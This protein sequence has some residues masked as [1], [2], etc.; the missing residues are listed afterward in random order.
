[1]LSTL[2]QHGSQPFKVHQPQCVEDVLQ[3]LP[4][5]REGW[6]Q[7]WN[8]IT[9]ELPCEDFVCRCVRAALEREQNAALF[10]FTSKNDKELGYILAEDNSQGSVREA[11]LIYAAYSNGK[12]QGSAAASL[13]FVSNW[14]RKAGYTKLHL[15]SRRLNGSAMRLFRKK[16]GFTPIG[17]TFGKT[18]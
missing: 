17:V 8:D 18:I 4:F 1:M 11:L 5:L 9:R 10:V 6:S 2:V 12:Y 15:Y 7:L 13:E 16:L 3:F 14:A